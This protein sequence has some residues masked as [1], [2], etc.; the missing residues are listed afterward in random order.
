MKISLRTLRTINFIGAAF[1]LTGSVFKIIHWRADDLLLIIGLIAMFFATL[2]ELSENKNRSTIQPKI[3]LNTLI[4]F[5]FYI[6]SGLSIYAAYLK[7]IDNSNPFRLFAI[8]TIFTFVF[9]LLALT[10][11]WESARIKKSEKIMWTIC[12]ILINFVAGLI[13]LIWARRRIITLDENSVLERS[14]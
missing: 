14:A 5:A 10:E 2:R 13:Y 1:V 7:I 8:G 6:G 4:Y 9:I 12:L 3:N 11:I